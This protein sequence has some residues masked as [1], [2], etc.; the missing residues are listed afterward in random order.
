MLPYKERQAL[1]LDW[2]KTQ[3]LIP[4]YEQMKADDLETRLAV[5]LTTEGIV[6]VTEDEVLNS[7]MG[8][9]RY[10]L[11]EGVTGSPRTTRVAQEVYY[12]ENLFRF[13]H[14]GVLAQFLAGTD[15]G[16]DAREWLQ[17]I[18]I[19]VLPKEGAEPITAVL[20]GLA[21]GTPYQRLRMVVIEL[22][23]YSEQDLGQLRELVTSRRMQRAIRRL[24]ERLDLGV[25]VLEKLPGMVGRVCRAEGWTRQ[26][27][28]QI[29]EMWSEWEER[30]SERQR[31]MEAMG[32]AFFDNG[33]FIF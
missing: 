7:M 23:G 17:W 3:R 19:Q 24:E 1:L 4:R 13:A 16:F 30:E 14:A 32:D 8:D 25:L 26:G 31:I 18:G 9:G 11:E 22:V 2:E 29:E 20:E 5:F 28:E 10:F 21:P 6:D 33:Q 27:K 15:S 12:G